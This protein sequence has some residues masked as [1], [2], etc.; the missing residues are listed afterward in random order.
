[1][2][3]PTTVSTDRGSLYTGTFQNRVHCTTILTCLDELLEVTQAKADLEKEVE[4]LR[5]RVG[6]IPSATH[7]ETG[8]R[9]QLADKYADL[10]KDEMI[11]GLVDLEMVRAPDSKRKW[12][13][14]SS[15]TVHVT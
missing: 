12:T 1:M 4:Q 2:H 9:G 8:E 14:F 6:S 10:K 11:G 5:K 3:W 15:S 13:P 7:R